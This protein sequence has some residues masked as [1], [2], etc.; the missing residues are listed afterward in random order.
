MTG[1][2]L[3]YPFRRMGLIH[4]AA[5]SLVQLTVMGF[6]GLLAYLLYCGLWVVYLFTLIRVAACGGT[7][8]P[9]LEDLS[10]MQGLLVSVARYFIACVVASVPILLALFLIHS[11]SVVILGAVMTAIMFPAMLAT[12]AMTTGCLAGM[13]PIPALSL[14]RAYPLQYLLVLVV[15]AVGGGVEALLN[16]LTSSSIGGNEV[17]LVSVLVS[18]LSIY[19]TFVTMRVLGN[20]VFYAEQGGRAA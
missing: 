8:F 4:L 7:R 19:V 2:A 11:P 5:L 9:G 15:F 13:N 10:D 20:F 16:G 17:S 18:P 6:G 3:V 1:A 12:A 14:I